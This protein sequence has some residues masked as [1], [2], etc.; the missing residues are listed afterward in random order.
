ML[1][2]IFSEFDWLLSRKV[3]QWITFMLKLFI[4]NTVPRTNYTQLHQLGG[5]R[6][7]WKLYQWGLWR[8]PG[9]FSFN[10]ISFWQKGAFVS[11][12]DLN[13][14]FDQCRIG[15]GDTA[16]SSSRFCWIKLNRFGQNQNLASPKTSIFSLSAM[17]SISV[18]ARPS[19]VKG[20]YH[21]E[22]GGGTKIGPNFAYQNWLLR[23]TKLERFLVV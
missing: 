13:H 17:D 7:R 6:E 12:I 5:L 16:T 4:K 2:Q 1:K 19:E 3:L 15:A 14:S 22:R 9:S 11:F 21:I 8:S 20:Q 23:A 10:S 18:V